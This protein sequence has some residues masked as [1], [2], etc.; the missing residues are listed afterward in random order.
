[1]DFK[2]KLIIFLNFL[3]GGFSLLSFPGYAPEGVIPQCGRTPWARL[4][5]RTRCSIARCTTFRF[6]FHKPSIDHRSHT[7][8]NIGDGAMI[9]PLAIHVFNE[10]TNTMA[11]SRYSNGEGQKGCYKVRHEGRVPDNPYITILY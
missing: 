2:E 8:V 11:Y 10:L 1:M 9:I 7:C 4:L 6:S 3:R 5:Y